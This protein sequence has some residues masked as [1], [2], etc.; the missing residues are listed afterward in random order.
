MYYQDVRKCVD[1]VIKKVGKKIVMGMPLALG[2]PNYF[3]N[4][5]YRRAKEDPSIDL[6]FLSALFLEKPT[7][8]SDLERRLVGPIAERIWPNWPDF[9][10]MI[11]FRANRLPPNVKIHEF[12]SRAATYL[13][14][15]YA[16]RN[17]ISSNYTHVVRDIIRMGLN[18]AATMVAKK[19][20][21]GKVI[22]SASCNAD[23]PQEAVRALREEE[24]KGRKVATILMVNDKLPFMYGD[25]VSDGAEADM[26]V[27]HQDYYFDLFTVPKEPVTV[28]DHMIGL[29][30]STLVKDGG[31]L[32]IGIGSLGDA[33]VC[34]L[35]A[36]QDHNDQYQSLIADMK[37]KENWPVLIDELGGLGRFEEGLYGSSEMLVDGFVHLYESGILK[38]EVYDNE[39]IQKL[40]NEGKITQKVTPEM[41]D[42]LVQEEAVRDLLSEKDVALLKKLGVF[43]GDV[44]YENRMIL[45]GGKRIPADLS[46]P[47]AK[48]EITENALGEVL[49]GGVIMTGSF[50]VGPE[51]F[52]QALRDLPE[53]ELKKF[54]MTGVEVV[55]QLYGG[56]SLR[57]LQRIHG[58]FINAGLIATLNGAVAS[59]A[60]DDGRVISGIGGQYNFVSM[61]HE[62]KDGRG[63]IMIRSTRMAGAEARSNIVFNYGHCSVPKHLRDIVI[64][65]YGIADLRGKSDEEV[66]I[67]LIH[68]ADSRFQEGLLIQAK[69][70]GKV[71]KTYQIP[72]R[73][74]NNTPERLNAIAASYKQKGLFVVFPFGTIFKPEEV[75]LGQSL[76]GFKA[77]L[78]A[79][80]AKTLYHLVKRMFGPD[81]ISALPYLERMQLNNPGSLKEKLLKKV[82]TF[83]LE[84]SGAIK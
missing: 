45:A 80:K 71:S 28:Q 77:R 74:R 36:R 70:A 46:D 51:R 1:D 64:T 62:L 33:V 82:V 57:R 26:I 14:V 40:L 3:A 38:R 34:G 56:E 21:D 4:E 39:A 83:A 72:E 2:K 67:A 10:F 23:T 9:E 41:L 47:A 12:F 5:F 52:Y 61:A 75:A 37:V 79:N 68:V 16:Q 78:E 59:D 24:K 65:E 44:C 84:S 48:K 55:N 19:I 69:K 22:Y 30:A 20:I 32:Q 13:N 27:D 42:L 60:L 17:H 29:Y 50:F 8:S 31:T 18:V 81:S 6:T 63:M 49:T 43:K 73:F 54:N 25:G 35:Q 58:R 76:R 15:E 53:V 7:W 66:A 11:D